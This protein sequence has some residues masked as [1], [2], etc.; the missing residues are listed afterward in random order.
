MTRR[1]CSDVRYVRKSFR[2]SML[3]GRNLKVETTSSE[4]FPN[5]DGI[6]NSLHPFG[7][8]FPVAS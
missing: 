7:L 3:L 2:D 5:G 8:I 6:P 4:S 1:D